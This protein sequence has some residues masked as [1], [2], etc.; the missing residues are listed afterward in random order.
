MSYEE[1]DFLQLSGIQHFA[2]CRRQWALI[3]IEGQWDEN[4][5]T[6]EGEL[7]H[8]NAHDVSFSEKRGDT[9]TVRGIAV[10]SSLMG[11]SGACDVVEFIL[12]DNGIPI[13]GRTGKYRLCPVEYKRG[14]P[15]QNDEDILQLT[16]QAMCLEE[17]LCCQINVGYLFYGE[18]RRRVKVE[19]TDGLKE[20]VR[21]MFDEMHRLYVHGHTPKVKPTKVCDNC[22]LNNLCLPVLC[23]NSS[24]SADDYIKRVIANGGGGVI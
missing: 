20:K 10:R 17:M 24:L 5:R 13:Q 7:L 12:D 16:A 18:I 3:H 14:K 8:K 1:D 22:S 11:V 19:L 23:E 4:L 21:Q 9:I 2:F 6:V 15:K